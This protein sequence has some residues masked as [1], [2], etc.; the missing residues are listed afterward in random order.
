MRANDK[1][2]SGNHLVGIKAPHKKAWLR[3]TMF[4]IPLMAF[5]LLIIVL[6]NKA[7]VKAQK[8]NTRVFKI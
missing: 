4:T 5:L 6:I 2:E 8:E 1:T 7:I 3:A